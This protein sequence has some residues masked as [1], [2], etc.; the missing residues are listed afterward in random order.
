MSPMNQSFSGPC[1]A[2][3]PTSQGASST[4]GGQLGG[5]CTGL[6][7]NWLQHLDANAS[8]PPQTRTV[9][10]AFELFGKPFGGSMPSQTQSPSTPVQQN[11][12]MLRALTAALSGDKKSFPSWLEREC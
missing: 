3:G 6:A 12:L 5:S 7:G 2:F 4:V 9:S 8:P 10:S 1:A 11:E